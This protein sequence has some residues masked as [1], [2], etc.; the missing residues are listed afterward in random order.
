MSFSLP[1]VFPKNKLVKI[2]FSDLFKPK[3]RL[4]RSVLK[5]KM[6]AGQQAESET[7]FL[8]K[9]MILD[10]LN[11]KPDLVMAGPEGSR[12]R[13]EPPGAEV[14]LQGA[15]WPHTQACLDGS[16]GTVPLHSFSQGQSLSQVLFLHLHWSL[17]KEAESEAVRSYEH[18][19]QRVRSRA[20][21]VAFSRMK[22]H[23]VNRLLELLPVSRE[24]LDT[25]LTLQ[26]PQT[27]R[28]VVTS[29]H[30]IKSVGIN[31]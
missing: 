11:S 14:S 15:L 23:V 17:M 9:P 10:Q 18:L 31:G 29:R 7:K 19:R 4:S 27:D 8:L 3:A 2:T 12:V 25:R 13:P 30:E 5:R 24:L 6:K 22:R 26:V 16:G 20:G 28:A 1:P 21:D